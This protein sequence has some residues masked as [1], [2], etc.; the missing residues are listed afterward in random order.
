MTHY[1]F[2]DDSLFFVEAGEENDRVFQDILMH[3]CEASGQEINLAKSK[4][5]FNNNADDKVKASICSI[6]QLIS[7]TNPRK[8]LEALVFK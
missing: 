8:Y 1:L 3:C 5:L 4:V 2:N 7:T 6:L